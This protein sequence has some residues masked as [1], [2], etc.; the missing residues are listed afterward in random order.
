MKDK[1]EQVCPDNCDEQ[2]VYSAILNRLYYACFLHSKQWLFEKHNFKTK[3]NTKK[4]FYG[5]EHRQVI[6]ELKKY[7]DESAS[8]LLCLK[9]NRTTADYFPK[10][11]LF[12]NDVNNTYEIAK[13]ILNDLEL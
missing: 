10:T 3:K 1:C 4:H 9:N 5:S 6:N 13:N 12:E 8:K 11:K 7:K 2:C